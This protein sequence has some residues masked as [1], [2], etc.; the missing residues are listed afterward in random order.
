MAIA[1]P[2]TSAVIL[3]AVMS[4]LGLLYARGAFDQFTLLESAG[5]VAGGLGFAFVYFGGIYLLLKQWDRWRAG[6]S[7]SE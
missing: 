7:A 5:I 1:K 4:G 3:T 2:P 6:P